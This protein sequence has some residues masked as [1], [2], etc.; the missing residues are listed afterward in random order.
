MTTNEEILQRVKLILAKAFKIDSALVEEDCHLQ[1]DLGLDS[2]ELT[3]AITFV[4]A[5][6]KIKIMEKGVVDIQF[7]NTV[8]ELVALI[9]RKMKEVASSN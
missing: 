9:S 3:D 1:D 2:I 5:E 4:E 7:P 6:F 8:S